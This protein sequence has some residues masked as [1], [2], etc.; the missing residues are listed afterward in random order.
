MSYHLEIWFRGSEKDRLRE[1]SNQD[2]ESYH[3]HLTFIRP[4]KITSSE[5]EIRRKIVDYCKVFS[6]IPFYMEGI[7]SFDGEFY[8]APVFEDGR[9]MQFNDGLEYCINEDVKFVKKCDE[10]KKF[11]VTVDME[12]REFYYLKSNHHMLRLTGIRDKKIWF[13]YDF[14]TD[15]VLNRDESLDRDRWNNT[16][17]KFRE[18]N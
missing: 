1:I 15:E 3:P 13:S 2:P 5:Y 11:H 8:Y 4:F 18:G 16:I 14:V 10:V 17:T 6:P 9:L 12:K 7:G